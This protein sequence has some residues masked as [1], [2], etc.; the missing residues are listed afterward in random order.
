MERYS[1]GYDERYRNYYDRPR[2]DTYRPGENYRSERDYRDGNGS[3]YSP[4][5]RYGS[6]RSPA[7]GIS[8]SGGPPG[9]GGSSSSSRSSDR[10]HD[11]HWYGSYPDPRSLGSSHYSPSRGSSPARSSPSGS[12][13][14]QS[15][16]S[17]YSRRSN[18]YPPPHSRRS[19][20]S[21]GRRDSYD[22]RSPY[23]SSSNNGLGGSNSS[24]GGG[25]PPP[26]ASSSSSSGPLPPYP[27]SSGGYSSYYHRSSSGSG[28]PMAP[29][30]SSSYSPRRSHHYPGPP[31]LSSGSSYSPRSSS[32]PPPLSSSRY[33]GP[34]RDLPP[35]SGPPPPPPK[36]STSTSSS[37]ST[38][39]NLPSGSSYRPNTEQ[40]SPP[41]SSRPSTP[42]SGQPT[43]P[44]SSVGAIGGPSPPSAQHHASSQ[45]IPPG[46]PPQPSYSRPYSSHYHHHS[47]HHHHRQQ[48]HHHYP[49][50][51]PGPSSLSS[52]SH[53][54]YPPSSSHLSSSYRG[55]QHHHSYSPQPPPP[56][57]RQSWAPEPEKEL[58]RHHATER[59]L[60]TEE[61]K[62]LATTRKSRFEL[63]L[64]NWETSKLDHQLELVQKQYDEYGLEELINT[65]LRSK[66]AGKA[67]RVDKERVLL[68]G[69]SSGVGRDIALKYASRGAKLMLFA[70]RT[71]LLQSLSQEC[72]QAGSDQVEFMA[73]DVIQ[74]NDLERLVELTKHKLGG[75]DTVV[76]CAGLISVR[77]FLDSCGIK[78]SSS[79]TTPS[80]FQ[81]HQEE[82]Q[83]NSASSHDNAL[84]CIT[85]VNYMA[86]VRLC[87]LVLPILI[88]TS[89][90]PNIVI[91][92]SLAG[93]VGAPT[94]ALY[95]AS[96]HSLHGFFDSLR[97]EVERYN[98]H[99]AIV[100][101]G[102]VDTEL[103]KT[104]VDIGKDDNGP[105]A[106]ST[107]GKLSPGAVAQRTIDASDQRERE[108][109]IPALFGYL[110]IWTK[111]IASRWVDWAAKKKY[112]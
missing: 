79:S 72:Q 91:I 31:P 56:R 55:Y 42:I 21:P 80:T 3:N 43:Q 7:H 75:I 97:V 108:V 100:C 10:Y 104:A 8:S 105:I 52:S 9:G 4:S 35:P 83:E 109:Y 110:A 30:S 2:S 74:T 63:E 26:G 22:R 46:Y 37:S 65:E 33:Y 48:H 64:A 24:S 98:V 86:A 68:V 102:T 14:R 13:R 44:P 23:H 78:V 54:P 67:G 25:P 32:R 15:Y 34:P 93:K 70:R 59:N 41:S 69:C 106:G 19:S 61:I 58:E 81:V 112:S 77:P 18:P 103:R 94:R 5:S 84:E 49:G 17:Y 6:S 53:H 111:L 20:P 16:G 87:R 82:Q 38:S 99:I 29:Y 57:P 1:R 107:R 60:C 39:S 76:Y 51:L 47:P 85:N 62:V 50:S 96:K 90:A 45:S 95:A 71:S 12:P 101:P 73:G 88:E 89:V 27:P 36:I 28:S 40:L 11:D 66:T 92:S